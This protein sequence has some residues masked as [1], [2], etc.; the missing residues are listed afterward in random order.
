MEIIIHFVT[1]TAQCVCSEIKEVV[2][3]WTC[4]LKGLFTELWWGN[5]L[6]SNKLIDQHGDWRIILKLIYLVDVGCKDVYWT[7]LAQNKIQYQ[8]MVLVLLNL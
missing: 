4:S 3:N 1:Y 6:V 2:K 7:E 5:L 8:S